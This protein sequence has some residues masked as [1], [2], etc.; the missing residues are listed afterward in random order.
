MPIRDAASFEFV[1]LHSKVVWKV[2]EPGREEHVEM[3][4]RLQDES[5]FELLMRASSYAYRWYRQQL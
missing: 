2:F 3:V 5:D 4:N 1:L